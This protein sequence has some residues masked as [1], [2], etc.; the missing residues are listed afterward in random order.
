M[1]FDGSMNIELWQRS[2]KDLLVQQSMVKALEVT[3]RYVRGKF[4][5]INIGNRKK[6]GGK[7]PTLSSSFDHI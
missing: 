7:F 5:S 2:M 4:V 3:K 1:R 6:K